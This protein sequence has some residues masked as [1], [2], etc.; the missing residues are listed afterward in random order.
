MKR[1]N[2]IYRIDHIRPDGVTCYYFNRLM[3]WEPDYGACRPN[4]VIQCNPA[5]A[6]EVRTS[7]RIPYARMNSV[8]EKSVLTNFRRWCHL[9]L[10]NSAEF[11]PA[12]DRL[13]EH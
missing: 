7:H 8:M 5:N 12:T 13:Q 4:V 6:P 11:D 2:L 10:L 9:W 1:R 3:C